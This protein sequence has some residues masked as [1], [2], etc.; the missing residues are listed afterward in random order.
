MRQ[1]LNTFFFEEW[2]KLIDEHGIAHSPLNPCLDRDLICARQRLIDGSRICKETGF[3][4]K[5]VGCSPQ[6]IL[7]SIEEYKILGIWPGK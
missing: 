7:D 2:L 5:H 6:T 3:E 1:E 4:Y